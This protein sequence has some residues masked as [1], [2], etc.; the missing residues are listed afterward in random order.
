MWEVPNRFQQKVDMF[1]QVEFSVYK[2][3][4]FMHSPLALRIVPGGQVDREFTA[5]M[6]LLTVS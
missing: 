5:L 2:R 1:F 4:S 6:F 3:G